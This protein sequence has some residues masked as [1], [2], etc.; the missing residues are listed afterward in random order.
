MLGR[1]FARFR[2]KGVLVPDTDRLQEGEA[3]TVDVGDPLAGGVQVLLCRVD[4]RVH[5]LDSRCPHEGGRIQPGP[6]VDGRRARCP[7]HNYEFD[8]RDG[9]AVGVACRPARTYR[10]EE[11]D[12]SCEVFV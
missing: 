9:K 1:L 3:R 7:L 11:R 10:V 8:P 2:K 12:G 5:A 4:G 6:L